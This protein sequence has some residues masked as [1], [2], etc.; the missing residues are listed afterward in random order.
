MSHVVRWGAACAFVLCTLVGAMRAQAQWSAD[1]AHNLVVS[2][3]PGQQD[4]PRIAATA[5]GGFYIAWRDY[6]SWPVRVQRLDVSG[7]AAWPHNGIA[8]GGGT[9]LDGLTV[10]AKGNA[11]VAVASGAGVALVKLAPDGSF[12]WREDGVAL[13]RAAS[14]V[15]GTADG[16][17]ACLWSEGRG[18][19]LQKFD[20]TG[21]PQWPKGVAIE[22]RAPF[23]GKQPRLVAADAGG[24]IALWVAD[25]YPTTTA[26]GL[27]QKFGADGTPLWRA[28]DP[29]EWSVGFNNVMDVTVLADGADGVIAGWVDG[30]VGTGVPLVVRVQR[31][32][33][34]GTAQF[35]AG[36]L[37]VLGA[38]RPR[39]SKPAIAYDAASD[40]IHVVWAER[41]N[42]PVAVYAQRLAAD[43]TRV[44][45]EAGKQLQS[46]AEN[47]YAS[48]LFALP[49]PDGVLAAWAGYGLQQGSTPQ[50]ITAVRLDAE[51]RHRFPGERVDLK[52]ASTLTRNPVALLGAAGYAAFAWSDGGAVSP[53]VSEFGILAQNIRLDGTLGNPSA[54]PVFADGFEMPDR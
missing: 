51:G 52:V 4:W 43:G 36:G 13:P 32:H 30:N 34:D 54:D 16:G 29:L 44:W 22:V 50:R 6:P 41:P 48:D 47:A 17:V 5:D 8:V 2:D 28:G 23:F 24:V 46:G 7:R 33:G 25:G 35:V 12:P 49:A 53:G 26:S 3:R 1:P 21:A 15:V 38:P 40:A 39:A 20:A 45:G 18:F 11:V 9:G 14:A 37:P 10:D 27:A 31:L 42:N 19:R